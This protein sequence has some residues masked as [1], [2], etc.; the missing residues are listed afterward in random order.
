MLRRGQGGRAKDR[1]WLIVPC[2][3]FFFSLFCDGN[4]TICFLWIFR[5]IFGVHGLVLAIWFGSEEGKRGSGLV[6]IHIDGKWMRLGLWG[7]RRF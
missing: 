3:F 4:A 1:G 7:L 6:L 5:F 2:S